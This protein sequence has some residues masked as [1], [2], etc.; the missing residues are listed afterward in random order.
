MGWRENLL[1]ASYRRVPFFVQAVEGAFGRRLAVHEFPRQ[2]FPQVED[3]GGE[4]PREFTVDAYVLGDDFVQQR[5]RL[6]DECRRGGAPL[7]GM[8]QLPWW[9]PRIVAC[10]SVRVREDAAEGRISRITME[11]VETGYATTAVPRKV[12]TPKAEVERTA[13]AAGEAAEQKATDT[14]ELESVPDHV[15][16]GTAIELKKLGQALT[17]LDLASGIADDVAEVAAAVEDLVEKA[18]ELATSPADA[19]SRVKTAVEGVLAV[20][21]NAVAA[22]DTYRV[23]IDLQAGELGGTTF[24]AERRDSNARATMELV[25]GFAAAGAARAIVAADFDSRQQAE[26]GREGLLEQ[27]DRLLEIASDEQYRTL[28]ALRTAVV[29]ALPDRTERLP[30][31]ETFITPGD[32][33]TLELAYLRYDD[34]TRDEEIR[35]RNKI[36]NPARI[37][38]L[39]ELQ[40][41][42]R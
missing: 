21:R 10:K 1:P 22:L 28:V 8:L 38:A 27:Y 31:L 24:D 15:R 36:A 13:K 37:P 42:S 26:Q 18:S 16:E 7:G 32:T 23:L 30:D 11:F 39:A 2:L 19:I 12:E 3:L 6:V 29:E 25:H 34:V 14:L 35:A 40:L 17:E 20:S 41:L 33:S 5:S 4:L 9:P